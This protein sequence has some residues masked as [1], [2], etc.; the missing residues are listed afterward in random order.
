[1][2]YYSGLQTTAADR[3]HFLGPSSAVLAIEQDWANRVRQCRLYCDTLAS[4]TFAG[5]NECAGYFVSRVA[6]A[7]SQLS[8]CVGEM[9]T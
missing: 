4:P 8:S 7:L 5:I 2:T 3:I 9:L 1:V 6:V